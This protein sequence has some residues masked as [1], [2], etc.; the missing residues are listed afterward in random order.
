[1]K[2][3]FK[4]TSI[5]LSLAAFAA[6]APAQSAEQP[7]PTLSTETI[8]I[9]GPQATFE[10]DR[11]D[12]LEELIIAGGCFWCVES[13]F[14]KLTGVREAVSGYTGGTLDNPDYKTVS[15][16][17]T[18]HYEAVKVVFDPAIVTYRQLIDHYW[19]TVDPT[20]A[21]GQ[22]CDKGTSYRTAIFVQAHQSQDAK[23]SLANV[24][25]TKPFSDAIVT[26]ILPA[27]T[28]Y[29]AEDYHQDY[30]KKNSLKYKYYRTRCG[31]DKR[32]EKLWDK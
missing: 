5:A 11:A 20:D 22:F 25:G 7:N 32:L 2:N 21:S 10:S 18:G 3:L 13:D 23:A 29:D 31:R 26:P 4:T 6:C 8:M 16:T 1:M 19:T 28:F 24:E 27:V 30:Y 12:G 15:Y 9:S 14:E 17:E